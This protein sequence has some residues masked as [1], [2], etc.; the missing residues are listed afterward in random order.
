MAITNII[1]GEQYAI[2]ITLQADGV[3]VTPENAD[4]VKIKIGTVEKTYSKGEITYENEHWLFPITQEDSLSFKSSTVKAQAQ[5]KIGSNVFS[6]GLYD[7]DVYS[8]IIRSKF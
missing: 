8:S 2:E 5:Y 6:T 4:D 3:P 7:V 1:Q